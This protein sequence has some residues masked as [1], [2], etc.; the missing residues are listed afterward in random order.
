MEKVAEDVAQA[1]LRMIGS[2]AE[3]P[4]QPETLKEAFRARWPTPDSRTPMNDAMS[5]AAQSAAACTGQGLDSWKTA[6]AHAW[7][8][9]VDET[10]EEYLKSARWSFQ[11]G[12][13]LE[14]VETLTDAVR[15]TLG[16]IAAV[17][18]WPHN[19]HDDLYRIAAALGSGSGWPETMEEFERALDNASEEGKNFGAAMGASM[20]RPRM[21]K[22]G[23]YAEYPEDAEEDGFLFAETTIELA[24]R[25][26]G[27]DPNTRGSEA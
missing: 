14:G 21:L 25:L 22:F 15:A 20:G 23:V 17:R 9:A 13:P 24:N 5:A 16:H 4:L 27:Q 19:A 10:V 7:Q 6:V 12:D 11:K 3:P 2:A 26:A 8:P 18:D 1:V